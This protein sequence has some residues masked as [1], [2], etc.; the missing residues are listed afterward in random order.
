MN[1]HTLKIGTSWV[2]DVTVFTDQTETTVQDLTGA[3]ADLSVYDAPGGTFLFSGGTDIPDPT[4]GIVR[5]SIVDSGTVIVALDP[6]PSY[7]VWYW[8]VELAEANGNVS[9]IDD[10]KLT[11]QS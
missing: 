5:V 4:N 1:Q 7:G 6:V 9:L 11:V 3:T 2:R 10:G 8:A